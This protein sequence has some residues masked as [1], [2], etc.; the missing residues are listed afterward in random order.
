MSYIFSILFSLFLSFYT[1]ESDQ[2]PSEINAYIETVNCDENISLE[3]IN[4][5]PSETTAQHGETEFIQLVV[6]DENKELDIKQKEDLFP[7][8]VDSDI[9]KVITEEEDELEAKTELIKQ[10]ADHSQ[11]DNIL[12][13]F[14]SGNGVVDYSGLKNAEAD[15]DRYL[16]YLRSNPV[17]SLSRDES[18][19]FWINTYNAFTLKL[20]VSNYPVTSIIDLE[21]GKP[22]DKKWINIGD[23]T[24][25]LNHIEN[26]IIRPKF[27]D[28]RIHF[29]VNCAAKSCPPLANTAFTASNLES[30]LDRRTRTFINDPKFTQVS[31]KGISVSKIFEWYAEDFGTLRDYIAKY[32][33]GGLPKANIVFMEYDWTLNGR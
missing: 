7:V 28:A 4:P 26:K 18:L 33:E 32:Y 12:K 29:A 3:M 16:D 10:R 17:A 6:I 8:V 14:V 31:A 22:W 20:I 23:R 21:G 1:I 19:A 30:L 25:S 11:F 5:E 9:H 13:R 2:M 15:L 24:Y 27:N